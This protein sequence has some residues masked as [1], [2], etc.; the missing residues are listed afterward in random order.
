MGEEGTIFLE[1][2]G[3]TCL[4]HVDNMLEFWTPWTVIP[5]IPHLLRNVLG[6]SL[7][8]SSFDFCLQLILFQLPNSHALHIYPHPSTSIHIY[9]LP[10]PWAAATPLRPQVLQP[11]HSGHR[12]PI[13][14]T[15]PGAGSLQ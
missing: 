9:P 12:S 5:V 6:T 2:L 11:F 3:E 4:P 15:T 14:A 1:L 10:K 8:A 7:L 13:S